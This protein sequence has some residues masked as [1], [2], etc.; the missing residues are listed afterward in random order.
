MRSI[1]DAHVAR[2]GLA[3]VEVAA[4]DDAT[5]Y[6]VQALLVERCAALR[7]ATAPPGSRA[8]PAR[9]CTSSWP[10]GMAGSRTR[11]A[12]RRSALVLLPSPADTFGTNTPTVTDH[13]PASRLR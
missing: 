7:L 10:C 1:V 5:A 6:A 12:L 3:V 9:G 4:G 11:D 13:E 2:P 8:S